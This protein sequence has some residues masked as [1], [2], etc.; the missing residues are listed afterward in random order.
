MADDL[1]TWHFESPVRAEGRFVRQAGS[2]GRYGHV[3][4]L[5]EPAASAG[6]SFSWEVPRDQIP[7][8][9]EPSVCEGVR[10]WFVPG[11]RFHGWACENTLVRI[12]GG[13]FHDTDSNEVSYMMA[14]AEAFSNAVAQAQALGFGR[15]RT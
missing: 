10:R 1:T 12:V 14:A 13:S 11:A 3:V 8:M 4:L 15:A 2:P 6:L 9:F 7:E 5:L